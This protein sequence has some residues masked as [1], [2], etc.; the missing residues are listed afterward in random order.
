MD[1]TA[2][3]LTFEIPEA[4]EVLMNTAPKH[5]WMTVSVPIHKLQVLP[6]A[7]RLD[8]AERVCRA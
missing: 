1:Q 8:I 5:V 7:L 4:A 6:C 3:R 2:I